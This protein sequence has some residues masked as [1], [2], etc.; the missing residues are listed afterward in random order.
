MIV[1]IKENALYR[2]DHDLL[3]TLLKDRPIHSLVW[4]CLQRKKP[5][6]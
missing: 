4:E 5:N 6:T 2:R 1:N 3:L